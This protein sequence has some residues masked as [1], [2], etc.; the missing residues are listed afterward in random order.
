M[1]QF[2]RACDAKRHH[3]VEQ[4]HHINH[5]HDV[6]YFY[7]RYCSYHWNIVLVKQLVGLR[8][9]FIQGVRVQCGFASLCLVGVGTVV[10]GSALVTGA[11]DT[12]DAKTARKC[13]SGTSLDLC[14][15]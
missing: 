9:L 15:V 10:Y 4:H 12:I 13:S 8:R 7:D 1:R 3:C 6:D 14:T 5:I 2:P 11:T